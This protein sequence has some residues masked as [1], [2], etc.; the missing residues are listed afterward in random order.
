MVKTALQRKYT[1]PVAQDGIERSLAV[2]A[3]RQQFVSAAMNMGWQLAGVVL[4]PIIIGVQLDKH[5]GTAPSYTLTALVIAIGGAVMV[6]SRIL[7][8]VKQEQLNN[9]SPVA[10]LGVKEEKQ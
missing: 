3:A 10:E 6:V 8:Q 4:I 9:E 7:K 1:A 2:F 5:F